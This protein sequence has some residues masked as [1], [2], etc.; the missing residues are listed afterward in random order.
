MYI[1]LC[2]YPPFYNENDAILFETIMAGKYEFHSPYW[3][4]ISVEAKD[5]I[6]KLLMVDPK[7]RTT[8]AQA[9][10][11]DWFKSKQSTSKRMHQKFHQELANHNNQ[12]KASMVQ[13]GQKQSKSTQN[14]LAPDTAAKDKDSKKKKRKSGQ[15][16]P[17]GSGNASEDP[18]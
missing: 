8:A 1:I 17:S 14:T 15:S 6:R 16:S 9:L 18:K 2:G 7:K 5:L 11:H 4:H 13:V 12:R 10:Q 3:D